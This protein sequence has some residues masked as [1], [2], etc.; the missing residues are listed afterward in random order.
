MNKRYMYYLILTHL[1]ANMVA[2]IP[3]T[4][5]NTADK[6]AIVSMAIGSFLGT[7]LV[8]LI[9][10][11]FRQFPGKGMHEL[12]QTHLPKWFYFPVIIYIAVN[13]FFAGLIQ[14]ASFVYLI[15]RFLTPEMSI[16]TIC[17]AFVLITIFGIVGKSKSVLFTMETIF[18]LLSPLIIFMI[19]KIVGNKE[20]NWDYVR[21]A[22]MHTTAMPNYTATTATITLI[23]L[24][25]TNIAFFNRFFTNKLHFTWKNF[26]ILWLVSIAVFFVIYF[27]PFG[28]NG[29]HRGNELIYPWIMTSDS[30][31][32]KFGFVERLVFIF[33][34]NF[35][36]I[37]FVSIT[38]HWHSAARFL[39]A[40][41]SERFQFK[42]KDMRPV[43]FSILFW[44][45]AIPFIVAAT[46]YQLFVYATYFYNQIPLFILVLIGTMMVIKRRASR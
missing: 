28:Y 33:M 26:I 17:G 6:G 2:H 13:W 31:R 18:V 1:V 41:M 7:S 15:I 44:C 42:K 30:V 20:L 5:Q 45:I 23:V 25:I 29:Y 34:L 19:V 27:I 9:I 24:G 38:V 14:L 12:A 4:L 22:F 35:L 37:S 32:M 11:A 43:L 36:A 40:L 10:L 21:V 3:K 8:M 46:E 16:Y 39:S